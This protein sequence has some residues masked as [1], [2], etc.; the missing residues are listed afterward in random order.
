MWKEVSRSTNQTHPDSEAHCLPQGSA[1]RLTASHAP[2]ELAKMHFHHVSIL[3]SQ[4]MPMLWHSDRHVVFVLRSWN[5]TP[6]ILGIS[7]CDGRSSVSVRQFRRLLDSFGW[8]LVARKT[9]P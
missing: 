5:R 6:K 3:S 9:K 2:A 7:W 8:G 1:G 4:P